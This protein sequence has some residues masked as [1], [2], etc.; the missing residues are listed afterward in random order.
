VLYAILDSM[1]SLFW[2]FVV[3]WLAIYV[4]AVLFLSVAAEHFEDVGA[5]DSSGG[6]ELSKSLLEWYGDLYK[7]MLT[8]FMVIS[9]GADW[10]DAMRPLMEVHWFYGPIF[11]MFIFGMHFGV[12]NVVIGTFV[13]S[14]SEIASRDQ[15]AQVKNELREW[16][17]YADR[18]RSF[19]LEAD[20]DKSGTLSWEEFRQ[21]LEAPK[22][23]ALFQTLDLGVAQAHVLFDLLDMDRSGSISVEEFIDGCMRLK[24]QAKAID[25]NMV[26]AMSKQV[27]DQMYGFIRWS[28]QKQQTIEDSLAVLALTKGEVSPKPA[29]KPALP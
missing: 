1:N 14:A 17:V 5:L 8:L 16:G 26:L 4:F 12:L 22:V 23:R 28:H 19:F 7:A 27:Y 18:M 25:M 24:G 6:S 3:I 21:H 20:L 13:A 10:G 15:E 29:A 2:C 11:V 9:G